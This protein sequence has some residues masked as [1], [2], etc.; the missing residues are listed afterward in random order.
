MEA[1]ESDAEEYT[2]DPE[3]VETDDEPTSDNVGLNCINQTPS[4]HLSVVRCVL[5]QPTEMD[6]WR[7]NATFHTFTKIGDKSCKVIMDS[8]SCINAISFKSL[9][10]FE[11][12]VVPHPTH[13]KYHGLTPRHCKSNND[14]LF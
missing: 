8:K 5:S 12:E 11:L 3:D 4:T 7:K 13:L 9:E 6:G 1:T 14:V 10:N 2:Y